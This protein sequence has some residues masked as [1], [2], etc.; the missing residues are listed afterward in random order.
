MGTWI[1][2]EIFYRVF[3]EDMGKEVSLS[4]LQVCSYNETGN[5]LETVSILHVCYFT[6]S[7]K[8]TKTWQM[9]KV[10]CTSESAILVQRVKVSVL[11]T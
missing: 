3:T 5:T 8:Q 9:A 6:L 10:G 2:Y 11:K 1:C 4:W 7:V